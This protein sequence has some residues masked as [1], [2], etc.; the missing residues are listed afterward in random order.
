MK[1]EN[2]NKKKQQI[3]YWTIESIVL[4]LFHS[5]IKKFVYNMNITHET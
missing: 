4:I 5:T 3:I 1:L 2:Y